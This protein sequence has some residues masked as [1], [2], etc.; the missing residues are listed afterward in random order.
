MPTL[1]NAEVF[2]N[3]EFYSGSIE[4]IRRV[5]D[6]L[7]IGSGKK[8][9][10]GESTCEIYQ[11]EVDQLIDSRL[12]A[13]YATPLVKETDTTYYPAPIPYIASRLCAAN[14][15]LVE[16]AD[17]D[18]ATSQY[19]EA[20]KNA[21]LDELDRLTQGIF[22]GSQRLSGQRIRTRSRV[23]NTGIVPLATSPDFK[24]QRGA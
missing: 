19:A 8:A 24:A 20:A 23:V 11:E 6:A 10:F 13:Y 17:I 22:A 2:G 16:L 7:T 12:S 21:A 18:A 4:N 14:I 5:V 1:S 3:S 15:V 9:S